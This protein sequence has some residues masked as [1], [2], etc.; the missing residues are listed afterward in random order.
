M[1]GPPTSSTDVPMKVS[2]SGMLPGWQCKTYF[3]GQ[4]HDGNIAIMGACDHGTWL[5]CSVFD[6]AR[7]YDGVCPDMDLHL[8]RIL[9]SATSM[10]MA[11]PVSHAEIMKVA[12][13][14]IRAFA[15]GAEL[16]IRPFMWSE[17][18]GPGIISPNGDSTQ[19]SMAME[20]MPMALGGKEVTMTVTQLRKCNLTLA[21]TD[22]KASCLYPHYG[23]MAQEA[24]ARGFNTALALDLN[25]NVA[26]THSAN[27]FMVKDGVAYTPVA[28]GCFLAGIT[29]QRV[30]ALLRGAG[31]ECVEKSLTVGDFAQADEMFLTGNAF[32]VQPIAKFEE[33]VLPSPG[34]VAAQARALYFEWGRTQTLEHFEEKYSLCAT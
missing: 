3:R 19:F 26:E 14:G 6:G 28:N 18:A 5:G 2:D 8:A 11:P 9:R 22:A 10:G 30:L 1:E 32:K 29:R 25:G 21:P 20:A 34:P 16:Y 15:P 27:V 23:R 24:F 17:Y 31:V 12:I 7:Y 13:Q 33:R 4:W